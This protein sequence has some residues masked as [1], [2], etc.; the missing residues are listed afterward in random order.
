VLEEDG[1]FRPAPGEIEALDYYANA[2]A[3][4]TGT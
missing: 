3:H 1:L 2:I 4:L